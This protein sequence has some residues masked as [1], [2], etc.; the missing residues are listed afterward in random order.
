MKQFLAYIVVAIAYLVTLCLGW[1]RGAE[2]RL[3]AS[4]H[5][6][7]IAPINTGRGR[8][9]VHGRTQRAYRRIRRLYSQEPDTIEWIDTI[10]E[11][12]CFW[13]IGANIG[14]FSLYAALRPS[15]RVLAIEPS[16]SNFADLNK[17]IELNK[18]SE[19]VSGYCIAFCDE[20]K[21]DVLNMA[22]TGAGGSMHG[23][24]TETDQFGRTIRTAF[25]QGAV[26]FSVDDFVRT[27]SPPMPTHVKIDVD[28]IENEILRGGVRT[29][30][31]RS[32]RSMIIEI[33]GDH[34]S[35][36]ILEIRSLLAEM[37]FAARP[38]ASPRFRNVVF[39]RPSS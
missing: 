6:T 16:A 23:F 17:N 8:L 38:A 26:G 9:L 30:S 35:A 7:L 20:T 4:E 11:G 21:L 34:N 33:E 29:F 31:A 36:R 37:G 28:G 22:K 13:D 25:R 1:R 3:I 14:L 32:V 12:S 5:L 15:I 18:M 27:F 10:P 39:E 2:A 24:G 19:H